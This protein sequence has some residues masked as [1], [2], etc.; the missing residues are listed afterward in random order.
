MTDGGHVPNEGLP[1]HLLAGPDPLGGPE[2]AA[3]VAPGP[4]VAT[5]GTGLPGTLPPHGVPAQGTPLGAPGYAPAGVPGTPGDGWNVD[6]GAQRPAFHF[7]DQP[8]GLDDEDD[9]LLMPGPQGSWGEPAPDQ[10]TPPGTPVEP[11]WPPLDP[12]VLGA[13]HGTAQAPA[14]QAPL[15]AQPAPGAQ[16][17][18]VQGQGPEAMTAAQP[19]RRP[20]HAGPPIPDPS[21]MTGQ[22]PVRSLADRGPSTGSTPAHGIPIVPAAVQPEPQA[23][24]AAA[25]V[26]PV[27][28]PAPA[29]QQA[30]APVE[31][32]APAEAAAP[33]VPATPAET[34]EAVAAPAPVE[35]PAP[36]QP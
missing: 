13:A 7:V 18:P 15:H 8:D 12:P 1:E 24:P 10:Q 5:D 31:V 27:V 23:A 4:G 22:V 6:P 9:V 21:L 30:A 3:A 32:P 11:S 33:A 34:P 17:V 25:P 35:V 28:Q 26:A 29:V 16:T 14:P 20:L 36:A 2:G 19:P